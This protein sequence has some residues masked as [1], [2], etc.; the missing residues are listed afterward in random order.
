MLTCQLSNRRGEL[1]KRQNA[2]TPR[3]MQILNYCSQGLF[4]KQIAM[5]LGVSYQTVKNQVIAIL[6]RLEAYNTP[7]AVRIALERGYI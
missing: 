2:L 1:Y 6:D 3:Q 7:H 5:K 4:Q